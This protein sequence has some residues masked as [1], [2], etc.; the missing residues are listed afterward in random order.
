MQLDYYNAHFRGI[1]QASLHRRSKMLLLVSLLAL[2]GIS[3]LLLHLP[4]C[5]SFW[6][7]FA[8][9]PNLRG[10]EWP[11][12]LVHFWLTDLVCVPSTLKICKWCPVSHPEVRV[13]NKGWRAFGSH[14]LDLP[15]H[16]NQTHMVSSSNLKRSLK[17][18]FFW[19]LKLLVISDMFY[20]LFDIY[21]CS[22]LLLSVFHPAVFTS[23]LNF[24]FFICLSW[25][26]FFSIMHFAL[27]RKV[28]YNVVYCY[29]YCPCCCYT[30][31][32]S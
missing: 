2:N 9:S 10:T 21:Y 26:I 7:A 29:Y 15:A 14:S 27:L 24:F 6:L 19:N 8:F 31:T 4:P 28:L 18:F 13:C 20:S 32:K 25:F 16:W 3:T 30:G 22:L 17:P 5:T 23:C 12:T 1:S 11:C